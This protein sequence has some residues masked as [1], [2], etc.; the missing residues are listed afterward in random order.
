MS[1]QAAGPSVRT[2]RTPRWLLAILVVSLLVNGLIAGA[3]ASRWAGATH[4]PWPGSSVN[5]HLV[6]YAVTLPGERRREILRSTEALRAEMRPIRKVM[7]EARDR[8]REAL[9]ANPFDAQRF[10]AAQKQLFDAEQ[11]TRRATLKVI[12]AIAQQLTPQERAGFAEWETK[13]RNRRQAFWRK[14]RE[15]NR[16]SGDAVD[17]AKPADP[18][19]K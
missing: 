17:T 13:D 11:V 9:V 16:D 14:M 18:T 15:D 10:E 12:Q 19:K 2:Q 1:A 6:G 8:A 5:A 4:T 3:F 7:Q